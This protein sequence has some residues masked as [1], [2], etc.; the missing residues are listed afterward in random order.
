MRRSLGR[1][2]L[3]VVL[4]TLVLLGIAGRAVAW[5]RDLPDGWLHPSASFYRILHQE[6]FSGDEYPLGG[7]WLATGQ[8]NLYGL[9]E[10]PQRYVALGWSGGGMRPMSLS[11]GLQ[12]TGEDLV[13]SRLLA[14]TLDFGGTWTWGFFGR[15]RRLALAGQEVTPRIYAGLHVRRQVVLGLGFWS[16][17]DG[18]FKVWSRTEGDFRPSF[19]QKIINMEFKHGRQSFD[20]VVERDRDGNPSLDMEVVSGLGPNMGLVFRA[21]PATGSLGPGICYARSGMMLLTSHLVHPVLGVTHR[22]M[23]VFG[24]WQGCSL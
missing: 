17:V 22:V 16:Q 23:V 15:I 4:E 2:W 5:T 3:G 1:H 9:T 12:V 13:Q 10:L 21:N 7:V 19:N 8:T 20:L 18:F 14:G 24:N 6:N 11:L